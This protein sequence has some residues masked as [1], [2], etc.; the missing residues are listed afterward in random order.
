MSNGGRLLVS[1][2]C[3][4]ILL[5][6]CYPVIVSGV[7]GTTKQF[8][9]ED[10]YNGNNTELV[11]KNAL[12]CGT[13]YNAKQ[14]PVKNQQDRVAMYIGADVMSVEMVHNS[15]VKLELT[16]ELSMQWF[17]FYL[18]WYKKEHGNINT[19]PISEQDVW[20]PTVAAKSL[21]KSQVQNSNHCF[22]VKCHLSFNG[23]VICTMQCTFE[24]DCLDNSHNW[25][26]ETK[27]CPLRIYTPEFDI[28]QLSLFHFQRRLS[29]S[30]F[31][32]HP[33]KITSFQMAVVNNTVKPEFRMDIVVER[34]V[35]SHLVIFLM[36]II[37]LMALNLI[38]TWLR[39]DSSCRAVLTFAS[40]ALHLIY[41]SILFWYSSTKMESALKLANILVGTSLITVLLVALL[42]YS[43]KMS[44]RESND[45]PHLLQ[46]IYRALSRNATL[47]P[48]LQLDY[49]SLG[50]PTIKPTTENVETHLNNHVTEVE[51]LPTTTTTVAATSNDTLEQVDSDEEVD[52]ANVKWSVF[53][54]PFDRVAFCGIAT[55]YVFMLVMLFLA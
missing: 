8:V 25:A 43:E 38:I 46:T 55:A 9:C 29:Y 24:V 17:D 3:A 27:S 44:K 4:V 37:V 41:T 5:L 53:V 51:P 52:L 18:H 48:F 10:G 2:V 11:L 36:L 39:I 31:G 45:A 28:N 7:G 1:A 33:Y 22:Q 13:G 12:L 6:I 21:L 47:H 35:G 42:V 40:L 54:Q 30:V 32:V 20:T 26:F 15:N 23:E 50:N 49:I 16:V 19:I 34:M 14:R